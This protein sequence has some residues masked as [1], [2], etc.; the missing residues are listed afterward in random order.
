MILGGLAPEATL[1][2]H[3]RGVLQLQSKLKRSKEAVGGAMCLA[4]CLG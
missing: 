2:H 3:F 1:N 4:L